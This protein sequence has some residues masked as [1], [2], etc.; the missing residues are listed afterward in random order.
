MMELADL[1]PVVQW[2]APILSTVI[3]TAATAKINSWIKASELKRDKEQ[4][5]TDAKRAKEAEW[6]DDIER[7]LDDQ[8]GKIDAVLSAQCTQMR[9]D[10][11][12]RAHH[13][14]GVTGCASMDETQSFYAEWQEYVRLCEAYG[15]QN[16]FIDNM[17][18]QMMDLP[19]TKTGEPAPT[20]TRF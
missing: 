7:K 6:R 2:V 5:A 3:I 16:S 8:D 20:Y 13:H 15:I 17:V 1:A 4:A 14:I 12:H 9:S 11:I 18:H 19:E 10:L